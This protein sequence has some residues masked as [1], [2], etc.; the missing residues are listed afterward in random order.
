MSNIILGFHIGIA[1]ISIILMGAALFSVFIGLRQARA[2][3][4]AGLVASV[5]T[6]ASGAILLLQHGVMTP[7]CIGLVCYQLATLGA[8]A[9]IRRHVQRASLRTASDC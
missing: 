7:A 6:S 1:I 4:H 9:Y 8:W 2:V 3:A 5:A